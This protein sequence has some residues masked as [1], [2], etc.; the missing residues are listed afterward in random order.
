MT[1][2]HAP[3]SPLV[4]VVTP[5]YNG[6]AFLAECI[7]S[8]MAQTYENWEYVIVDN[9]STDDTAEIA[10]GYASRDPRIRLVANYQFLEIIPNWNQAL[11]QISQKSLYCKVLHADDVMLPECLERMIAVALEHPSVAIVSAYRLNGTDVDLDGVI[12]WGTEVVSGRDICR[13]ALLGRGYVFGAPSSLLV[14]A[15]LIRARHPFYNEENLHSDTEVCFEILQSADLG[16]VHQVLTRTRL[17]AG[18][19]SSTSSARLNTYITGWLRTMTTYGPVYLT[20]HE[21]ERR[22]AWLLRRYYWSLA[23]AG[24]RGRFRD[25]RYRAHH[26]AT[27]RMLRS[28]GTLPQIFPGLVPAMRFRGRGIASS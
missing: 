1:G 6:A 11:R 10:A 15:D 21:Y 28:S 13:L 7:E 18:S 27:L 26:G 25:P 8:V 24:L 22:L 9:C 23:K 3:G 2:T 5:V 19:V 12:P 4:S 17:H 20:R 16:F 14:R